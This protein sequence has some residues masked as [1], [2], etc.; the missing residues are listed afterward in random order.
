MGFVQSSIDQYP[1]KLLKLNKLCFYIGIYHIAKC[2]SG[3]C[4]YK[5]CVILSLMQ[6]KDTNFLDD[7]SDLGNSLLEIIVVSQ[8]EHTL[9]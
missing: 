4:T 1:V 7:I 8:S 5:Y 2:L 3:I 6:R 9:T